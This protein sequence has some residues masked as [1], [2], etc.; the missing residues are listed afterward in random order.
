MDDRRINR[1]NSLSLYRQPSLDQ[2]LRQ[3][4]LEVIYVIAEHLSDAEQ[5][6]S[7]V[8][9]AEKQSPHFRWN[10]VS[11]ASG[12]PGLALLFCFL[13]RAFPDESWF[14]IAVGY[15]SMAAE[16]TQSEPLTHPG[17]FEGLSG[18]ASV[19]AL[20]YQDDRRY[21]KIYQSLNTQL[22][23]QVQ[24]LSWYRE[25]VTGVAA[26][27]YDV[28]NGASG[29]LGYLLTIDDPD[30]HAQQAIH[31]LLTYLIWL[32]ETDAGFPQQHRWYIPPA[33][34]P[35][36]QHTLYPEGYFNCGLAH[37]AA[38]PLAA[39][40]LAW[41]T[42]YQLPGQ[43][44][45]IDSLAH[46]LT[47]YSL[48]DEWG[49]NWSVCIP[50]PLKNWQNLS[51]TRAAWCHG[52][53]GIARALWLAGRALDNAA[54]CQ[55]AVEAMEGVFRRPEELLAAPAATLCHGKGGILAIALRFAQETQSAIILDHIP[56]L[57]EQILDQFDPNIAC[58]FQDFDSETWVSDPGL[59][60][61]ACGA[62][63]ALLASV[64]DIAPTWDRAFLLA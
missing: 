35:P 15:L 29:I 21:S 44:A 22:S 61:G 13:A 63:L 9:K 50:Y 49:I 31:T 8:Q 5:V 28:L 3:R 58:G 62:V 11:L 48:L 59:R 45:A 4:T 43:R 64:T 39:L 27:D 32:A 34:Y 24:E 12:F 53:P 56:L 37:G 18:L 33:F 30:G 47:T 51:A 6:M 46:W 17:L 57:V 38:G 55:K 2:S 52:V 41:Q 19:V 16:A 23:L 54:L 42:G 60:T 14:E 10:A 25:G 1:L 7:M 40:A 36:D 20:L 26:Q